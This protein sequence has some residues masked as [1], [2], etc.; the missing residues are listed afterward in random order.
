MESSKDSSNLR[1]KA[2]KSVIWTVIESWG[3]Q[4]VSLVVFFILARLLNPE[5]FGLIALASIFIEF[6]QI[7]V[8]QGFSVAIIQRQEIDSEHLDTAFWTTLGISVLL[9]V[10]SVAGAGLTADF[11]KQP[12]LVPIIQCLSISFIFNGLSSVQQAVLERKFAFKSLAIRSLLAVI[13]GGIVGVWM[14]FLGFG[15]WSLVGQQ[16][17]GSF[18]QVIVL[19]RVSDWRP[20]FQ[21]SNIHVKEL[22][23][24]GINISAFNIINFFNRRAD[25]LLIGYYLGLVAL[26]YYSVAYKLLLVMMQV[27]ISTT[28][29]VALPIFSR[30]QA[31]PE[32]LLNAF[33][34]ATQFTSLIAFPIFLCV[35]VLATEFIKVFFG[36]QWIQSIPVLQILSLIGPVHL[37]FFYNNSVILALGKPSWR[38]WIQVINTVT[39][40]IGFALVVRLG[41]VAVA[42]AYVVR[43]Y[44]ILPISLLAINKLVKINLNNYLRLYIVPLVASGAMVITILT[45][46]YFLGKFLEAWML[47]AI[48][49][50]FGM[51]IYIL[52]L[53]VISPKLFRRILELGESLNI[54]IKTKV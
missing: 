5:T 11:F 31:E 3:R 38:L 34:T 24:F 27:L 36:E 53:S 44:L 19:W 43:G 4:G 51:S 14:A 48:A 23:N 30:L 9:T 41:I 35:P 18:I 15:V 21:F 54:K 37:I 47:L 45:T 28:T 2:V 46:K 39:N 12:Q 16:L 26:G 33:Y 17:S 50:I 49:G 32:R 10:L 22:F 20:G 7:F 13:I 42:S 1:Q 40:V 6:V 52:T 8:D 29:K 25:D